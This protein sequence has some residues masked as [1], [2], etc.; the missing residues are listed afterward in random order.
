MVG[1]SRSVLELARTE[2]KEFKHGY[3][4]VTM[5]YGIKEN[6]LNCLAD[7][8]FK[9]TVLPAK[10]S[11]EDIMKHN[12]DGVF[13][14]NGPGDPDATGK[15]A[16]AVIQKLLEKNVPIFGICMGH[17]LL[18]LAAG[19][20]TIK[21]HQGHRGANHPVK[22]LLNNTVEITSQ[23]LEKLRCGWW[24]RQLFITIIMDQCPLVRAEFVS[25]VLSRPFFV[26]L[27]STARNFIPCGVCF[28]DVCFLW[29]NIFR[30]ILHASFESSKPHYL[31]CRNGRA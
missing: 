3:H 30:Y 2:N 31:F 16:T 24:G 22:N 27:F 23:N 5:D 15:Y 12:P 9:V 25:G 26:L 18:A 11:F 4:A 29:Y 8:G 7:H 10:S 19:L 20:K 17:Q 21:L 13:L 1:R 14:S 28:L 6:I